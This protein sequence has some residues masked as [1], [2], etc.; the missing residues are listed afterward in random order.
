[1][2]RAFQV[3]KEIAEAITSMN[4]APV[5]LKFEKVYNP[6]ILITKKHYVGYKYESYP[7]KPVFEAKGIE[8]VR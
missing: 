8:T 6:C 3:G 1:M 7:S 5:K 2:Q 4:P